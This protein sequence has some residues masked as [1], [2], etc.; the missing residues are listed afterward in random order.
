MV[1]EVHDFIN[2][3]PP[4]QPP[5]GCESCP[6]DLKDE[7]LEWKERMKYI[8]DDIDWLLRLPR[9]QFWQQVRPTLAV[10]LSSSKKN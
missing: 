2:Y 5:E 6:E 9:E 10:T 4:P 3:V 1:F 8:H 7:I